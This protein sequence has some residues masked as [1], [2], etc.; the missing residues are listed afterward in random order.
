MMTPEA[1]ARLDTHEKCENDMYL[2][3]E[4]MDPG[5][6]YTVLS[7]IA[8][9]EDATSMMDFIQNARIVKEILSAT[10]SNYEQGYEAVLQ[11]AQID[12][13]QSTLD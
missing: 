6:I 5:D 9:Y 7:V 1:L 11:M 12:D 2:A 4:N 13:H 10:Q 3:G 8:D